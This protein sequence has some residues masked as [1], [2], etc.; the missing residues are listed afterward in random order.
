MH[1]ISKA[2]DWLYDWWLNL[3][4]T[5]RRIL[6]FTI[7][8]F[9]SVTPGVFHHALQEGSFFH[10]RPEPFTIAGVLLG[11]FGTILFSIAW[12][13]AAKDR[14]KHKE[15]NSQLEEAAEKFAKLNE[16]LFTRNDE[17]SRAYQQLEESQRLLEEL[18]EEA[19]MRHD[20]LSEAYQQLEES[21]RL[22]EEMHEELRRQSHYD[23]L[24]GLFNRNYFEH[25][26]ERFESRAIRAQRKE[27][28][29]VSIID[30][31]Y[32]KTINDTIGHDPGDIA[33]RL[34]GSTI[35]KIIRM[36]DF[37]ARI[38]GDEFVVIWYADN[39]ENVDFLAIGNRLEK[40]LSNLVCH[41]TDSQPREISISC[42]VGCCGASALT[43]GILT[44]LLK[45]ADRIMYSKKPSQKN[46]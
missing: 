23:S 3:K 30:L 21:Q 40:N 22:L 19:S 8:F 16:E 46:Q 37:A 4:N 44:D 20:E 15:L 27:I 32:L 34:V 41:T 24:T 42:S 12:T 5:T 36:E 13:R 43:V 7:C 31:N 9:V 1:T 39:E 35:K 11:F 6:R 10:R 29:C 45:T 38:G 2:E 17:L 14:K 18:H 25:E 28:L 33:L 26:I